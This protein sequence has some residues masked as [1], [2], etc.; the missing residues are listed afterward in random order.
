MNKKSSVLPSRLLLS[1]SQ[2]WN[3][4]NNVRDPF[5]V[6][7][8]DTT[9]TSIDNFEQTSYIILVFPLLTLNKYM[10]AGFTESVHWFRKHYVMY[11][12]KIESK[13]CL[14]PI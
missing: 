6:S 13:E 10:P 12:T 7:D 4:Q 1:Q 11:K 5:K 9:T 14:K 8:K 3:H 2:Q